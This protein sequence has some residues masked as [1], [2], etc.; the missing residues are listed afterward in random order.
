MT[1]RYSQRH[2]S[3]D[4]GSPLGLGDAP[5]RREVGQ[6]GSA[7]IDLVDVRAMRTSLRRWQQFYLSEDRV[8]WDAACAHGRITACC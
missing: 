6:G 1:S 5:W 4:A 2:S 8:L 7:S 3:C